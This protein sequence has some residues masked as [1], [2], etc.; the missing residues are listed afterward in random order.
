MKRH[1]LFMI[2]LLFTAF[3]MVQAQPVEISGTVTSSDDGSLLPGATVVVKGTAVSALTNAQGKYLLDA[4]ADAKELE[5]SFAGMKNQDIRIEGRTEIN[6]ALE[7]EVSGTGEAMVTALGISRDRK[8]IG[9]TVQEV[10][11]E[12]INKVITDNFINSLSGKVTGVYLKP[13]GNLGGSTNVIIRGTKSFIGDNQAMFVIDGVPVDNSNTNNSDQI[14]GWNGYDYGNN[15]ADINPNDIESISILKGA[16]ATALYGS[17][18]ANGV[19]MITTRKGSLMTGKKLGI[20]INSG[21][22]FGMYDKSTFPKYQTQYG[23]G[24]GPFHSDGQYP[25]LEEY[26]LD[27]DGTNDLVVPFYTDGSM[28]EKFNP[29]LMV[30]QW[31]SLYPESES[32]QQKTPW[33]APENLPGTFFKTGVTFSNNIEIVGGGDRSTYRLSYTNFNQTGI[34]PNSSLKRNNFMLTATNNLTKN[35]KVTASAHYINT[36]AKGRNATGYGANNVLASFREWFQMNVDMKALE[37]LY[38]KTKR[39]LTWNPYSA[40]YL[41]PCFWDNPYWVRFENYETDGRDRIIG[42]VQA[43]Y[44][45]ASFLNLMGRASVDTYSS[46]QEERMAIGSI[47]WTFGV[48]KPMVPS[49]YSRFDQS[50]KEIN[51]DLMANFNKNL[52]ENINLTALLGTNIRRLTDDRVYASTNDGLRIADVYALNVS[53]SPML[54]PEEEY[55]QIGTNGYFGGVSLSFYNLIFLDATYRMDQTST[56]PADNRTCFYPSVSGSFLFSELI[57]AR[58]LQYGKVRLNYAEV[59]NGGQWG[60]M[61]D[62]YTAS[63]PFNNNSVVS[64]TDT[65]RNPNLKEERT[66]SLEA[67]IEMNMLEGRIGLDAAVY[68][69]TTVD[70]IIPVDVSYTTGYAIRNLNG[71]EMVNRGIEASVTGVPVRTSDFQWDITLNWTRNVNEVKKLYGD[72]QNL[73]ITWLQG[74]LNINATVGEP[75][76]TIHGPDVE[77]HE[78]GQPIVRPN[79]YYQISQNWEN[80]IGNMNPDWIGGINNAF[81]YKDVSLSFLIDIQK[82]GDIFSADLYYGLSSGLYEETAGLNDL[83]NPVRDP[84]IINSDGT[85]DLASGGLVLDGVQAD[86]TK[87]T[88]RIPGNDIRAFGYVKNPMGRYVYDA[89]YVKLRELV[90]TYSLPGTLME[91]TFITN[92]SISLI[93]SNLWIIHKNLPHADPEASQGAGNIQGFQCGVMPAVRNFG[94]RVNLQF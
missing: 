75:Y 85:Y 39:N 56:L 67:G 46:L 29:D 82:G 63:F 68:Q 43:D 60:Y 9:Y 15:A 6:I 62:V 69:V 44:K 89:S 80:L 11:G 30:Y 27:G 49:G 93:G 10:A 73:L 91:K 13:S 74:G 77:Y 52:S 61:R 2:L 4:P 90:L 33:I 41:E 86:G 72:M 84:V 58:W 45:I 22:S 37:N 42:Y 47:P 71:G 65:K 24:Y 76:G 23:A 28:G 21:V 14:R 16:G 31:E 12:E 79:G 8:S 1:F 50:F 18:A 19:I 92:A 83:G 81:R 40:D 55:M 87:N 94:L 20:S 70:Q 34:M 3:Q 17:R 32:Y 36:R 57:D 25:G 38:N 53:L 78:N 48:G 64:V 7:L 5:V 59:G 88:V 26:D 54:P 66:K 51:M 35:F